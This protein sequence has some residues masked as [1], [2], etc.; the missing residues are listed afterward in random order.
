MIS[1]SAHPELGLEGTPTDYYKDQAVFSEGV[2]HSVF[3]KKIAGLSSHVTLCV[4]L[5]KTVGPSTVLYLPCS[6]CAISVPLYQNFS[7]M[8]FFSRPIYDL[9]VLKF[10]ISCLIIVLNK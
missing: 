9:F 4:C 6:V 2:V 10:S 1:S 5:K 3:V 8:L 7:P